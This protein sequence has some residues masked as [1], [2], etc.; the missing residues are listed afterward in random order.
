M[1]R[2]PSRARDRANLQVGQREVYHY[3]EG[4]D[5]QVRHVIVSILSE[6]RESA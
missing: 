5:A 4:M 1:F 3:R 6:I 2:R